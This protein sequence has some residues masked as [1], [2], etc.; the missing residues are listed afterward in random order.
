MND[1]YILTLW[2][3]LIL[4]LSAHDF[5]VIDYRNDPSEMIPQITSAT[6]SSNINQCNLSSH[7]KLRRV[8]VYVIVQDE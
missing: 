2:G 6:Q 7:C 4:V 3:K 1:I 5:C 8:E